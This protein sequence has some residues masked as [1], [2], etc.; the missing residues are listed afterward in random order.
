MRTCARL[1]AVVALL[2]PASHARAAGPP[3][4]LADLFPA[5]TLAYAEL[6]DLAELAPE[7]AAV[8][9]GTALEDS[10]PFVHAKKDAAKNL[11]ELHGKRS[12]AA[13]GLF[14]SPEMLGEAKKLR[15]AAGLVGFT[16]QGDP[17]VAVVVLT[18]DSPAAGLAARALVTMTPSL[19]RVGDVSKVPVFQYR[20]PNVNYDNNGVPTINQEKALSDGPHEPTFAYTPGLFVAGS[21]K[22]A[23]GHAVKRFLGDDAAAGLGSAAAF[24]VAAAA[25]RRAGLFYY[26]AFPDFCARLDA[27]NKARG[28]ARGVEELV[29]GAA[30]DFD[31]L[32]WFKM[33]ANARAVKSL[34][35]CVRFR[36]GGLSATVS[37]AFDPAHKSP[38]LD[39]LSG[40]GARV[41]LLH[42]AA[43]P[44]A[45][46]LGVTLPE[47]NRAAALLGFLDGVAK[48]NGELGRLPSEAAR[49][50]EQKYKVPVVEGLLGKT[51][52]VTVFLPTKQELPKD[53]K[54]M[55][56]LVLHAE[57]AAAA[58]AIEEFFPKLIGDLSGAAAP[59]Q[60]ATETIVGVKVLSLPG[61]GLAWNAPVHYARNGAAVVVGLDRK[62]V[63][64]AALADAPASA[65]GG[66]ANSPPADAVAFGVVSLGD[67]LVRSAE[68]PRPNGPVVPKEEEP[69]VL[70]NGNPLPENF[71]EDV[72][73]SRKALADA[74]AALPPATVTVRR[75]GSELRIEV[76]Q[77]KV[78]NG[79]L[80]AVIDAAANW[81]DKA[82]GLSGA[83]RN[84]GNFDREI[85]GR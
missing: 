41:E 27:A 12:L 31:L 19:R 52:A 37:A 1:I 68:K 25:H 16:D 82:G 62:L 69:I 46:A 2:A 78:Q 13:L 47:K 21:S 70:P 49:E 77:P 4:D 83:N 38:L 10:I 39:L 67:L 66:V 5:G 33:T 42:H 15:V 36:D 71:L 58:T 18:H 34:A 64:Q 28:T 35:G 84:G 60:A 3:A 9:K 61:T 17:E 43:R 40:P 85:F 74:L 45:F 65:A 54:A 24:K 30:G 63:A 6:S 51:R 22:A 80:K 14:A 20:A 44:A 26:V 55:P 8:F 23:V 56:M 59:P 53:A 76:F 81:A 72:K 79:V 50:M 32:A 57:D 75:V 11:I 7:V 73:K 29:G 48:A